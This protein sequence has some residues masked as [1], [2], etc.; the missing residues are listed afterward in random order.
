MPRGEREQSILDAATRIFAERGYA[1][2][3]VSDIATAAGVSKPLILNYFTSKDLLFAR[4]VERA[5]RHISDGIEEA[6]AVESNPAAAANRT[7]TSI[8]GV[9]A[10]WPYDWVLLDDRSA[11]PGAGADAG[12]RVREQI[13]GYAAAGVAVAAVQMSLDDPDDI[14]LTTEVWMGAVTTIVKWWLRHPEQTAE[15]VAAR[16]DRV[17]ESFIRSSIG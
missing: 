12:E 7:L 16:A 9:L 15:T 4:A 14:D 3:A 6:M 13:A 11:P 10:E 8:F 5:G 17:I 1:G 2:A